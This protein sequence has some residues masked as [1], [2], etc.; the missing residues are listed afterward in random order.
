MQM[1]QFDKNLLFNTMSVQSSSR[2]QTAMQDYIVHVVEQ[3]AGAEWTLDN[4]GNIYVTK[5]QAELYPTVVAHMDTVHRIVPD[6]QFSII[7]H[8]GTW[9]AFNPIKRELIGIGGDDK[10]GIFAA[11]SL[12]MHFDAIKLA[13]FVDEEIGCIGSEAADMSFF[14]NASMVLQTDRRGYGDFVQEIYTTELF[15][16][17][18]K[19][20]I[21]PIITQYGY[22]TT[23]LGG[24]TDVGQLK[25]NGLGVACANISSGY[26]L[27]HSENEYIVI[28]EVKAVL[29]MMAELIERLGATKWAHEYVA[30]SYTKGSYGYGNYGNYGNYGSYGGRFEIV[31]GVG[32]WTDF[33]EKEDIKGWVDSA[34]QEDAKGGTSAKA[35]KTTVKRSKTVTAT[36]KGVFSDTTKSKWEQSFD[37][38]WDYRSCPT[39][40]KYGLEQTTDGKDFYCADCGE[41]LSD[42]YNET[43]K[44]NGFDLPEFGGTKAKGTKS[45][46]KPRVV[47]GEKKE[48]RLREKLRNGELKNNVNNRERVKVGS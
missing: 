25:E 42:F 28:D 4:A 9:F 46:D 41:F 47:I 44:Q 16:K 15:G 21:T 38:A 13:F 12:L 2:N 8:D 37:S 5:G 32:V 48:S 3:V 20:A 39:C 18:F 27:A 33:D 22:K 24:I 35:Q 31:N 17:E 19:E 36:T 40:G 6:G 23:Y 45:A 30:P 34:I 11:L 14:D 26:Y 43:A 1:I 7:S 10:V 29:E